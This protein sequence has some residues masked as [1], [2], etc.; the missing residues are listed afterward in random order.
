MKLIP[1]EPEGMVAECLISI[2]PHCRPA[3]QLKKNNKK[4]TRFPMDWLSYS[5][6]T[7]VHCMDTGFSD[8]FL[9]YKKEPFNGKKTQLYNFARDTRNDIM[10]IHNLPLDI[11]L[12]EAVH[13]FRRRTRDCW[14]TFC[15]RMAD[16]K[17]AI[18]F[19]SYSDPEDARIILHAFQERFPNTVFRMVNISHRENCPEGEISYIKTED[20]FDQFYLFD[21]DEDV[22]D[23]WLGNENGWKTVLSFYSES[24]S[25]EEPEDLKDP[26]N[27]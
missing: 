17:S 19:G 2:G 25:N 11:P 18:L 1:E 14:E 12:D 16:V 5:A 26:V 4:R 21:K 7:L 3:G 22:P 23:F 27:V 24:G 13:N 10:T 6:E 15:I 20:C 9:E 8:F